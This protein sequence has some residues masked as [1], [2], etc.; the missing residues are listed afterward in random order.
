MIKPYAE[1]ESHFVDDRSGSWKGSLVTA[2]VW[3]YHVEVIWGDEREVRDI[4]VWNPRYECVDACETTGAP[5][6]G[7]EYDRLSDAATGEELSGEDY[8]SF[9]DAVRELLRETDW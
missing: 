1:P 6:Y 8:D 2:I 9:A 3:R 7:W 4:D 5:I